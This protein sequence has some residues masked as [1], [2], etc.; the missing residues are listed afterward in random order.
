M[1]LKKKFGVMNSDGE[2]ETLENQEEIKEEL[3]RGTES[4]SEEDKKFIARRL[5]E[6]LSLAKSVGRKEA[7]LRGN[8]KQKQMFVMMI[9]ATVFSAAAAGVSIMSAYGM[10]GG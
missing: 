8:S 2:Y 9:M 6:N 4:I 5:E 3:D 1:N 7:E 10:I